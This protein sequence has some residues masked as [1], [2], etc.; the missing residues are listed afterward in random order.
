MA[1]D[2]SDC[3]A[4]GGNPADGSR[5]VRPEPGTVTTVA[6]GILWVRMP[7]PF[8]LDHINLWVLDDGDG[9]A[10]VD[11]GIGNDQTRQLW[12]QLFEGP[13]AGRPV[14]RVINTH[15]HPDHIG[16]ASWLC[17]RFGVPFLATVADW[18]FG[19][20]LWHE[21]GPDFVEA[22]VRHHHHVGH[23]PDRLA[24]I[25][26]RGN[27]FRGLIAPPPLALTRISDGDRLEIGGRVWHVLTFG[28]HS[29]E[30]ACLWCPD[31][32]V[33]IAG[34]QILPTVSPV[35]AS[36]PQ[37]PEAEPLALFL[38]SL[39]KLKTLPQDTLV[40]PSHGAPFRT[41][42]PRCAELADHH[43]KRLAQIL[44]ACGEPSTVC[45]IIGRAFRY[46]L[47]EHQM[48]FATGEILAHL[49]HLKAAGQVLRETGSDAVWRFRPVR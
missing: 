44:A 40:L 7:L 8:A 3:A 47:D 5:Q 26:E 23:S 12:D 10:L 28:G 31:A 16:L 30:H 34:D 46:D 2:G 9:W 22:L 20:M 33:L 25:R 39:E 37:E 36:W 24:R 42:R 11:T 14:T 18:S 48:D 45:E 19:R 29:Y 4:D 13:L 15:F 41:L 35:I 32:N 49:N 17:D 21:D 38:D 43:D 27:Y 1:L 6:D